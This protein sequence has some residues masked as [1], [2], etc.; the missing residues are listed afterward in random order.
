MASMVR[1]VATMFVLIALIGKLPARTTAQEFAQA[2]DVSDC[3]PVAGLQAPIA[4]CHSRLPS[5]NSMAHNW[6]FRTRKV[7][8]R[9]ELNPS[10]VRG[11]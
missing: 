4:S 11:A 10:G 5:F 7:L 1:G 9:T 3:T 2:I 6:L 8:R